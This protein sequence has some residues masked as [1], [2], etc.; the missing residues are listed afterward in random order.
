MPL[1]VGLGVD[2]LSVGAARVGAVR[3]WIRSLDAGECARAA[4][5]ALA[6]ADAATSA[7]IGAA[8]LPQAGQAVGEGADGDDRVLPLGAQS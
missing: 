6:A 5:R 4:A 2:E 1:L 8:L 3:D 7:A